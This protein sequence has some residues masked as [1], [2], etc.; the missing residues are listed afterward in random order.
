[1]SNPSTPPRTGGTP[2][3]DTL[4]HQ[5]TFESTPLYAQFD[6]RDRSISPCEIPATQMERTTSSQSPLGTPSTTLPKQRKPKQPSPVITVEQHTSKRDS[7][8]L[9]GRIITSKP[10]SPPSS[11]TSSSESMKKSPVNIVSIE[12]QI[13]LRLESSNNPTVVM[14]L[15]LDGNIRYISNNWEYI[16]GTNI[17]K[18]INRPI[19]KIIIGNNE[20]DY[21]VFNNA[22][23]QMILDDCSY[24]V[25]FMTA[26]KQKHEHH[27]NE[28]LAIYND[29][30]RLLTPPA[31]ECHFKGDIPVPEEG[32]LT[33][34]NSMDEASDVE[35]PV[36]D[37]VP[38]RQSLVDD[39]SEL[40][41]GDDKVSPNLEASSAE[42]TISLTSSEVSNDG[43]VIE[44]E[45]QG[46]LIHDA[47]TRLPT[48]SMWTIR[49]FVHIDLDLTLP[50]ALIDLLG[51]GSEIFEGYLLN[52]QELGIIDE[53][54]VPQPKTILCRICE[55]NIP[56]W[57]IEKHS[58]LCIIE[59]RVNESLQECHDEIGEQ[60]ELVMKI[61]ESLASQNMSPSS[62]VISQ[63]QSFH[64]SSS[65]LISNPSTTSVESNTSSSSSSSNDDSSSS[66]I[67]DYKGIPL[68]TVSDVV[69]PSPRLANQVLTKN[70]QAR[71]KNLIHSK[72]FPFGILQK[73]I[74]LCDD[75]LL[76][77]P[78]AKNDDDVLEFSP[79]SE[80]ALNAVLNGNNLETNDLAIRQIIEDT[81]ILINNKMDT[82]SRLISI[83]QFS[84][85]IKEE[86][87][88]LVLQ[89]VRET[90]DKIR[91]QTINENR[92]PTPTPP[93]VEPD[94]ILSEAVSLRPQAIPL[95]APRPSRSMSPAS[96]L[97]HQSF[98]NIINPREILIRDSKRQDSNTSMNSSMSSISISRTR[99]SLGERGSS[100]AHVQPSHQSRTNSRE[101][102]DAIHNLDFSKRS[103]ENNSSIPSPRRHLSP[104]PYVEKQNLTSLQRN[105]ATAR[106]TPLTSPATPH[107]DIDNKKIIHLSLSTSLQPS[108]SMKGLSKQQP[109]LS[110]L[111]VSATPQTRSSTGGV[112]DYE[113]IKPISKG[114][115]GSVFLARRKLTGDYVAIKCLRK[116]DMIAK[117]QV[118]NVKSERAVMMRQTDSPYVAQLY[119]SFQSKDYLYL[120]MEY[121]NGGDCA[122]LLKTLGVIGLEWTPRYI[123]EIIVGVD[124]LHK[125]G[126]IHRDLKPD[127]ILIDKNGHLKLTDFGLSRLGVVGRQS[128]H[129]KSSSNEHGI[130][131]FKS[132]LTQNFDPALQEFHHKRT[133]SGTPFTLSPTMEHSKLNPQVQALQQ[134]Y[135]PP[136]QHH[137]TSPALSFLEQFGN[138]PVT[139]SSSST[140]NSQTTFPQ[141]PQYNAPPLLHHRSASFFKGGARSN[142]GGLESPLLRPIIPRTASESS[143]ALFDD[144]YNQQGSMSAASN[145]GVNYALYDPKTETEIKHFVGTPDYLAPETIEGVGQSE[146][147]DWWSIGCMLFEF[148]FG[149]PPFHADSPEKVFHNILECKI[150]WPDLPPEEWDSFCTPEAKDL[151]EKLLTLAPEERLGFHGASEIMSHPYFAEI[152]WDNLFEEKAPF[153]PMLDDPESTDYFDSRGADVI[154]FPRDESDDSDEEHTVG[155]GGQNL[156][157]ESLRNSLTNASSDSPGSSGSS[158]LPGSANVSGIAGSGKR[159][160]RGSRLVDPGEFGSFRFRNLSV[161]EK[162]NKDVINRLKSEHLEHRS[163]FS[164]SS[165]D[166]T[167][168]LRSPGNSFSGPMGGP[169]S[170]ANTVNS[171]ISPFK[172]SS[173][174]SNI[175]P[176]SSSLESPGIGTVAPPV[177]TVSSVMSASPHRLFESP[178]VSKH[179]RVPSAVSTYSSG[180]EI[181]FNEEKQ[182]TGSLALARNSA[183]LKDF[184]PMSSDTEEKPSRFVRRRASS[185]SDA[186]SLS[187]ELNV[188]Y[189]EPI[190]VVRH[191]VVKLLEKAGCVVVTVTDGEDLVKRATSRV[192]FDII[193]T[194]LKL[195]KV[196]AIDAVKL[197]KFTTSTNSTTPIVAVTGFPDKAKSSGVFDEII[198]KP[199]EF[200]EVQKC[201]T[202]L[203]EAAIDE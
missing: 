100:I 177:H 168:I 133:H 68:P 99:E 92:N 57:F 49:P 192:K 61:F 164:S 89:T 197:I 137:L 40:H 95:Q 67:Y 198:C 45:A 165:S 147:S 125:R 146:S 111:L 34:Y 145:Q 156:V 70:F 14:E 33:P 77:N 115:F 191:S 91:E 32:Q 116:R 48:H 150:D 187:N 104:A 120:V 175:A 126:I 93:I 87:D 123:A 97:L 184:T 80:K 35:L 59:H 131:L 28:G 27:N 160:R 141:T 54:S 36:E 106:F 64:S 105:T 17:K 84:D 176:R 193:F 119:S 23:D 29:L 81:Q 83:L 130:E 44:L 52:L 172:R 98:D 15:D 157:S 4:F 65:S 16:V 9:Q 136:L 180:D 2:I 85:K 163:S 12:D 122:N 166:S 148:L 21:K 1:M 138:S 63:H 151:I 144:E 196:E 42:E 167:P 114:A 22:I 11:P 51:F 190:S 143:F 19:S 30:V 110:P 82:L 53:E 129:R 128:T 118:L 90:V 183:L 60:R 55:N 13:T 174:P 142:S 18:I 139:P 161:L 102:L 186:I 188:L 86:I 169:S 185:R 140:T 134:P 76:I 109:P 173:S 199:V 71:H 38:R 202:K 26:T 194:A 72:K 101:L 20:E 78:P 153:I 3:D 152:D 94:A 103:S 66:F 62:S 74:E 178:I 203:S 75:A 200:P 154:Q 108:T 96:E 155:A 7:E 37:Y 124:D 46:I 43:E 56:A 189:C 149:Y 117:N 170:S 39:I 195:S 79:G 201:I 10:P 113:I 5:P 47:K 25:K 50:T 107:D 88:E 24:K 69:S 182:R 121:L 112:R 8:D 127:N 162:Q 181:I 58:D 179:E 132:G 135:P 73:V 31:H 159:E 171:G 158:S 6:S 41:L